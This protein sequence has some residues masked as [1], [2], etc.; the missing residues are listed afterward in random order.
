[1]SGMLNLATHVDLVCSHLF[2]NVD[3]SYTSFIRIL[4]F[5]LYK[6]YSYFGSMSFVGANVNDAIF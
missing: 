4:K 6:C 2:R 5:P 3:F 1:M